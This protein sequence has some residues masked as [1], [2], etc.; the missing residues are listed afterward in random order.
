[1]V[2]ALERIF[3]EEPGILGAGRLAAVTEDAA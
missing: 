2:A 1:V 3:R